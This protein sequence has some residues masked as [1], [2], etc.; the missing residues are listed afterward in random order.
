[1]RVLIVNKLYYPWIGGVESAARQ[2]AEGLAR[3]DGIEVEV[4]VCAKPK[5]QRKS[6]HL[7]EV[8]VHEA[9]SR[10]VALGMPISFDFFGLYKNLSK[11][12][13]VVV[14]NHPSPLGFLA[15]LMFSGSKP[16]AVWYH[17]D[18]TRQKIS[19]YLFLPFI[20][21]VLKK[22]GIV[23]VSHPSIYENSP[24][25]GKFWAKCRVVAYGIDPKNYQQ[26]NDIA[27]QSNAIKAQNRQPLVLSVGRLVYYKGFEYLIKAFKGLD[28]GLVIIGS[29][30]L[31]ESL[32]ELIK[33]MNLHDK[34]R[35]IDHVENLLPYY[36][37][38]DI[39]VLPSVSPAEAF[40][41]VQLE[42]MACGKPVINTSL[43]T[44]VPDVSRHNE[45]GLTVPPRDS[46]AL[47]SAVGKL[48]QDKDLRQRMGE[49]ALHRVAEQYS[50]AGMVDK[51]FSLL[52]ALLD[53]K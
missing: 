18:I 34:V 2:L 13:S 46:I 25:L 44:A 19:K 40:G 24:V 29:G 12:A 50:E 53:K 51:I 27:S 16:L 26:T 22:A 43:P 28:A 52:T 11:S 3:K 5:N 48:L 4:L 35:I 39:F 15:Y 20:N 45:T 49:V 6:Y 17:A 36:F 47:S 10:W 8:L 32:T 38:A 21:L 23:L 7:N 31:K 14:L 1:M 41:L 30:Y 33:Q 9:K 42:A 37:A